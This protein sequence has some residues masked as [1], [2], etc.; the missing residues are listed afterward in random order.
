M[1]I[2]P[3]FHNKLKFEPKGAIENKRI[4]LIKLEWVLNFEENVESYVQICIKSKKIGRYF[5][6]VLANLFSF[7]VNFD[8]EIVKCFDKIFK[9]FNEQEKKLIGNLKGISWIDFIK[10]ED[11]TQNNLN[12][13]EMDNVVYSNLF[14]GEF[15]TE[16]NI[17]KPLFDDGT[18][19]FE[20]D[21]DGN[22]NEKKKII[23]TKNNFP[24]TI[25]FVKVGF[26]KGFLPSKRIIINGV[27]LSKPRDF[28]VNLGE[29][30]AMFQNANVPFHFV[31]RFYENTINVDNKFFATFS[32]EDLSKISQLYI[33]GLNS[34]HVNTL[35]LCR[36]GAVTTVQPTTTTEEPTTTT[37]EPTTSTAEPTTETPP[38]SYC[39]NAIVF[40]NVTV[41]S[42][43]DLVKVGFGK[44]FL[45]NKRIIINGVSLA[46]PDRIHINLVEDGV[47]Y[48]TANVPF[49]FN[50]RFSENAVNLNDKFFT[51]FSRED[52]SKISQ[53][54]IAGA[55]RV[56]ALVLCPDE[57]FTTT[58]EPTTITTTTEEPITTTE[59]PTTTTLE[60]TTTTAELTTTQ[61]S[62]C[63]NP[64]IIDHPG[65][66]IIIDLV[67][68]GFGRGFLPNKSIIIRGVPIN[69]QT[70]R[71]DI[72]LGDDGIMMQTAN[73][74][75]HF[76]PR[77]N[78]NAVIRDDWIKNRG[79][80]RQDR[81]GG[82]PFQIG[83]DFVL[84]FIAAPRNTI[85]V[86]L[87]DKLFTTF[88]R[89]DL[90]N[91]SQ[92]QIANAIKVTTV[93]L[94]PDNVEPTTTE[95]PTTTTEEH[96][97]T[98]EE[99][100][101]TTT[102]KPTTTTTLK[103][104]TIKPFCPRPIIYQSLKIPTI[105]NLLRAFGRG[106][107]PNKRIII[108]GTPTAA[109]RFDINLGEDGVMERTA[110]IMF[111][112]STRF[113]E[114]Q[115]VRDTW[116]R[117]RGWIRQERTGGF[118]FKVGQSFVLE[119]RASPGNIINI[120]VNNKPFVNFARYDLSRISQLEI[121][122][123]INLSSVTLCK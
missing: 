99:P 69:D 14:S 89:Q 100:S 63:P 116:I 56:D 85:I 30:G 24:T 13:S 31:P 47:M 54:Y 79:W 81:Y 97:T 78:E 49:H 33:Y 92:L 96:T 34:I 95:E 48:Q 112:F 42:T 52:L 66:P 106:F 103:P 8:K 7:Y 2:T 1:W 119:F 26:G 27:V 123:A 35:T 108:T 19:F 64:I 61:S 25:D 91:V 109:T 113:A 76:N 46:Q 15:L 41:P 114:N 68:R 29:D 120:K 6:V 45:P 36:D 110:N 37:E 122:G 104:T 77:F 28:V 57:V 53:L 93:V 70:K 21:K 5:I 82:F 55:I 111:H 107:V 94:C 12:D 65:I 75:F 90:S 86:N 11:E 67:A 117:N 101:T 74:L 3:L 44:G 58:T 39:P 73:I 121:K 4:T 10:I 50:P 32:R 59:E 80:L 43:F 84:E 20:K 23:F 17:I 38:Y 105:I 62:K 40:N 88:S 115:V 102:E 51:S 71:I 87:D 16:Q 98:T 60:P 22:I 18:Y 9:N 118:P 83:K 72:N